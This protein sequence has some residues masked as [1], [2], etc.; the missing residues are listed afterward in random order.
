MISAETRAEW[1]KEQT[2]PTMGGMI[3]AIGEYTPDEFWQLLDAYE[4]AL[5]ALEPFASRVTV[6]ED[7]CRRLD[8]G[9]PGQTNVLVA[10]LH[11]ARDIVAGAK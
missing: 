10:D 11:R 1:R 3:S 5:A 7:T 9:V 4:E 2:N 8:C 6:L